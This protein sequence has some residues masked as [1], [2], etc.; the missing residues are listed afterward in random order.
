MTS[1]P[2]LFNK[3]FNN[4]MFQRHMLIFHISMEYSTLFLT[5]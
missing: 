2:Q 4:G 3:F 1:Y 5:N